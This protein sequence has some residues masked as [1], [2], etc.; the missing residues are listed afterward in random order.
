VSIAR[1]QWQGST[2]PLAF[3][4]AMD[5]CT[6]AQGADTPVPV[7]GP[8]FKLSGDGAA[9]PSPVKSHRGCLGLGGIPSP[10]PLVTSTGRMNLKAGLNRPVQSQAVKWAT[11]GLV[12]PQCRYYEYEYEYVPVV[13]TYTPCVT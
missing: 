9:P 6:L 4:A 10:R 3:W 7:P 8:Y 11:A 5:A 1:E 2:L 12:F 13:I